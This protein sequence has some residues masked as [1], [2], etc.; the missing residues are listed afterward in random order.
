PPIIG[1]DYETII[2][3]DINPVTGQKFLCRPQCDGWDYKSGDFKAEVTQNG[4]GTWN[5]NWTGVIGLVRDEPCNCD[6]TVW[7]PAKAPPIVGD[8]DTGSHWEDCPACGG[9]GGNSST[10]H[11]PP[12]E[13]PA[14]VTATV[15]IRL[16]GVTVDA[17]Q[18]TFD[19]V[20]T[21]QDSNIWT[22]EGDVTVKWVINAGENIGLKDV[23]TVINGTAEKTIVVDVLP[24]CNLKV[25]FITP[26]AFYRE[27]TEVVSTFK[28]NNHN[29]E[30][31]LNIRPKHQLT[32]KLTVKNKGST[33]ATAS[34]KDIVIPK[35]KSNVVYFKWKVPKGL[36]SN[37]VTLTCDVNVGYI[38]NKYEDYHND[39]SVTVTH[40]VKPYDL[41]ETPDTEF[42]KKAPTWF[43][44][45]KASDKV[46][47]NNFAS[48]M[49]TK[50]SFSEWTFKD[51]SYILK[52]YN[53]SLSADN[54]LTPD[55]NSPSH[56]LEGSTY[57]MRSG[58]G[59]STVVNSKLDATTAP[60]ES[61]TL[62][63]NAT[64]HFGE[65]RFS[66]ADKK[67]RTLELTAPN[68]FEF[69]GNKYAKNDRG[70]ADFRRIHFTPL[71][72]YD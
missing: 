72:Y 55:V 10:I 56:K 48:S 54:K 60:K 25:E 39:N 11:H 31:G 29:S 57:T 34:K 67:Y 16:E 64:M 42:E 14:Q 19:M 12:T 28:I 47:F 3:G 32:A 33:I 27:G 49:I 37:E 46:D 40:Q 63:Q 50:T 51:N 20:T 66:N 61:Y 35:G 41:M 6:T 53:L 18:I 30:F 5:E 44:M 2:C 1:G 17:K 45:P 69:Y 43:K 26:N 24:A 38:K 7:V 62:P 8:A 9:N 23:T 65:Y 71:Y 22:K 21:Q 15:T 70:K 68:K 4:D 52:T 36:N 59:Y 13:P 58:Y